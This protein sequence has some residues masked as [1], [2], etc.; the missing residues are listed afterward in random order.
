MKA[1]LITTF[2]AASFFSFTNIQSQWINQNVPDNIGVVL[3][4]DFGDMQNGSGCGNIFLSDVYGRAVYTIN[5]G[6]N[7]LTSQVPDSSR[8]LASIQFVT[9]T[10]GFCAGAYNTLNNPGNSQLLKNLNV[11]YSQNG[12]LLNNSEKTNFSKSGENYKGLFYKTTDAGQSWNTFGNLP[13]DV[14][15]LNG[16]SFINSNTGFVTASYHVFGGVDDGI[17]KT[18]D[19]GNS[20][21]KLQMPSDTINNLNYIFFLDDNTGYATGF[22]KYENVPNGIIIK[23][24][25][26][27]TSW[28]L[29]RFTNT[30]SLSNINFPNSNTGF[31]IGSTFPFVDSSYVFKT[32][33]SGNN[34]ELLPIQLN[35]IFESGIDFVPGSGTGIIYGNI[36]DTAASLLFTAKTTDYGVT[37]MNNQFI[38]ES[39]VIVGSK[40]LNENNWYLCGQGLNSRGCILHST[41]GGVGIT[42]IGNTIPERFHLNQNYPN[43]F[44]PKAV[45]NYN[46]RVAGNIILKVFDVL[47][48]EV[49][50]LVNEKQNAGT[51]SVDFDGSG[52][53]SGIYFYELKSD[54]FSDVKRMLLLK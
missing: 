46:L 1:L 38:N 41:N 22:K 3:S 54:E 25:N 13:P 9:S 26:S 16:L 23:T 28:T 31:V 35:N 37:W 6:N 8:V 43:P 18:T 53:A 34:W 50:T 48:N 17:L 42:Q 44:N 11:N 52:L 51:Y 47:G 20:W 49:S 2:F 7:W 10:T 19:G 24:T 21:V 14:F 33:D 32:I 39:N 5:G 12:Q 15:Y 29:Q 4:M 45:I 40:L 36:F 30:S 27:G